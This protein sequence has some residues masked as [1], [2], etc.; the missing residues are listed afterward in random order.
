MLKFGD[1]RKRVKREKQ[2]INVTHKITKGGIYYGI[3]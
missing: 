1:L 2:K 3:F